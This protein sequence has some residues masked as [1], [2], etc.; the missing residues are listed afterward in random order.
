MWIFWAQ[1]PQRM[2]ARTHIVPLR[3]GNR[4]ELNWD[5]LQCRLHVVYIRLR[6][7]IRRWK[8]KYDST[9][10]KLENVT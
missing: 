10:Y 7:Y 2:H 3:P 4:I 9:I 6:L 8:Q 5:A 1:G